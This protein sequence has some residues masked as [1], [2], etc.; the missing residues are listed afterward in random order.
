MSIPRRVPGLALLGPAFIASVA[1]VDPGNVAT[2]VSAGAQFG[3]L[4]VWVVVLANLM[5]MLVQYLAAKLGL[6]S[7]RS[8][9]EH[10]GERLST[11]ARWAYWL[12]AEAVVIATDLAEV[13]GGAV[14]LRLL[15]GLPLWA[16]A[17]L[18]AV[19][20]LVLLAIGDRFGQAVL[21]RVVIG[22]LVVIAVGFTAGLFARPPDPAALF[23]GVLPSFAGHESLLLASGIIGATVMPHAIYLH[24]GL[25]PRRYTALAGRVSTHRLLRVTRVDVVVALAFAGVLNLSL[26]VV[27]ATSLQGHAG[28]D[29][30]EGVYRLVREHV[31][32]GVASLLAIALLG[33]GL[34][35]TSVGAA[36]GS[37]I[38]HGLVR[39]RIPVLLR[40]LVTL[41]PVF[42]IFA[43]DAD[44][45]RALVLSQVV[46][47]LGIPFA[48][49]PLITLTAR[50]S[51]MGV[52]RNHR[53]TTAL[54][55]VVAGLILAL[56][57]ALVWGTLTG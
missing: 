48:L 56:N 49:I 5:A 20:S 52:H 22:F 2:N 14:A 8:L 3:F 36:A 37:E 41:L 9:S 35:S 21:E 1:Y 54:A 15:F 4:L 30:L 38:M 34:V 51:T 26:L 7:G 43:V 18:T 31:G 57:A 11:R 24:S 19:L 27:A 12:Q 39:R 42:A 10:L 46:L 33:S 25:T 29:T 13:V 45:T 40:R 23:E 16:G 32:T 47:S 44:P 50:R 55:M 17:V 28:S 6:V 53:G